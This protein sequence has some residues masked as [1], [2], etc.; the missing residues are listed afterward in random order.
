MY[1]CS[2]QGGVTLVETRHALS[3]VRV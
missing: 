2:N 1:Q 3:Q